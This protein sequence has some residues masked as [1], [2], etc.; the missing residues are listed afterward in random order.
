[1]NLDNL[2]EQLRVQL[3]NHPHLSNPEAGMMEVETW[4][5]ANKP[6]VWEIA[7][8]TKHYTLLVDTGY[9]IMALFKD[10]KYLETGRNEIVTDNC[11]ALNTSYYGVMQSLYFPAKLGE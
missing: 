9:G 5:A 1:M 7:E 3:T 2:V 8:V 4:V 6:Y 11:V 10:G